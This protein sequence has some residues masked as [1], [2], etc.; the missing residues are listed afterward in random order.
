MYMHL[1]SRPQLSATPLNNTF[2]AMANNLLSTVADAG[3]GST[4]PF[5]RL[6]SALPGGVI[7]EVEAEERGSSSGGTTGNSPGAGHGVGATG[8]GALALVGAGNGTLL[9]KRKR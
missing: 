8:R 9:A 7:D 3:V 2:M 1:M 6:T 4:N 5:R